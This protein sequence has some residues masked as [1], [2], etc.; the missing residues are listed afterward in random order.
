M[1][2]FVVLLGAPT[3]KRHV[4]AALDA[5]R[6]ADATPPADVVVNDVVA[7]LAAEARHGLMGVLNGT[8]ILLHTNLGRAPL[9]RE[10]LDAISEVTGGAS[11]LE[12]DLDAG[13]RGSRYD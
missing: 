9:A 10:A 4:A 3:V 2:R 12:Y 1:A 13:T 8:G 5:A 11:N 6:A 7:R